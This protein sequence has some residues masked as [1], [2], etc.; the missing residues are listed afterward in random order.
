V[1]RKQAG[2]RDRL[3]K[4]LV[5]LLEQ[6][7]DEGLVFLIRQ[8]QTIIHNLQVDRVNSEITALNRE[9]AAR[10]AKGARG[11]TGASS[12]AGR[13]AASAAGSTVTIDEGAGRTSFI[14][15]IGDTRKAFS[16]DEMRQLARVAQAAA[17]DADGARRLYSW[18]SRNRRDVLVDVGAGT[19][20][21]GALL[22]VHRAIRQ[23]Y[24][25]RAG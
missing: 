20:A 7:D 9:R 10:G 22:E 23:R 17:N 11:K 18:L 2:P 25:P 12:R 13:P 24:R 8:A 15:G 4:E 5:S 19:A 3:R 6:V 14:I 21:H 1:A 16:L